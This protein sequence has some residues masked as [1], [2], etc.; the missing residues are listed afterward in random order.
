[1]FVSFVSLILMWNF[2][3]FGPPHN[4]SASIRNT[5]IWLDDDLY[6][7]DYQDL[8]SRQIRLILS[9]LENTVLKFLSG[10]NDFQNHDFLWVYTPDCAGVI[11]THGL[12]FFPPTIWWCILKNTVQYDMVWSVVRSVLVGSKSLRLRL[13]PYHV[14]PHVQSASSVSLLSC[15]TILFLTNRFCR[16]EFVIL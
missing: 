5:D 13:V 12:G 3:R 8:R 7:N 10:R 1:M 11:K 14:R 16:K 6:I 15:A 9:F 2:P 4:N